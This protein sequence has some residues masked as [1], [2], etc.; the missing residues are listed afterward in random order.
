LEIKENQKEQRVVGMIMVPKVFIAS[1]SHV[2][3]KC[4]LEAYAKLLKKPCC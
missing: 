2:S 1:G 3:R 4:Y